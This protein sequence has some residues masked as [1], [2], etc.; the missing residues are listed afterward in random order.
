MHVQFQ[1]VNPFREPSWRFQRVLDLLERDRPGRPGRRDDKYI[2]EYYRF[3]SRFR[4]ETNNGKMALF[5]EFPGIFLANLFHHQPDAEWR[6]LL[7]AHILSRAS[8]E[9]IARK[10]ATLPSAVDWYER[11]F[12]NVR[13]RLDSPHYIFKQVIG[14]L[15]EHAVNTS[16]RRLTTV[17]EQISYKFFGYVGGPLLLDIIFGGAVHLPPPSKAD[18]VADWLDS[19]AQMLIRR[20]AV[21]AAQ[22]LEVNKY[23]IMELLEV[24][25][26]IV[27]ASRQSAGSINEYEQNVQAVLE[28]IPWELS[29]RAAARAERTAKQDSTDDYVPTHV[30]PRSDELLQLAAG[31]VPRKLLDDRRLKLM[32]VA[33]ANDGNKLNSTAQPERKARKQR[34]PKKQETTA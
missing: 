16:D 6:W 24:H 13:D 32:P 20:K 30:E 28:E 18:Q 10:L 14:R 5:P 27:E 1:E 34:K 9:Q 15:D 7:Q 29:T 21:A 8:D 2:R 31:K 26:R 25:T 17:H 3:A 11:I 19:A 4:R 12:F 33:A 22:H 23:N